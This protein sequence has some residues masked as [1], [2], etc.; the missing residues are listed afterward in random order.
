MTDARPGRGLA[1]VISGPSGAGKSTVVAKLAKRYGYRVS[2][3][4]TTRVPR[5]GERD[6]EAYRFW[7]R[8]RFRSAAEAGELLEWSEHFD[9]L[10][11]TPAAPVLEAIKKGETILLEIDVKGAEQV[12][13]HLPEAYCIFLRAPDRDEME[14]RLRSRHSETEAAVRTRLQ[15]AEM[16][17]AER[18]W[19]NDRIVNDDL[20]GAV[21]KIHE[22]IQAREEKSHEG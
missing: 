11:G 8:E 15:R 4:A 20:D 18:L 16:E 10:Y 3:S 2:V 19:Y 22:L 1:V 17:M 6:G 12:M 9:N 21:E 13:K 5:S 7:S 14:R